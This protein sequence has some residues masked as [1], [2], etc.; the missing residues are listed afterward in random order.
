MAKPLVFVGIDVAQA[1][2]EVAVRPTGEAWQVANDEIAFGDLVERVRQLKPSLIVLEATGGIHLPV[3]A[4]LAA[5]KL[6]VVA[7]NPRQARDFAKAT[8]KLAKDGPYRR[9]GPG[10]FCRGSAS[11][12]TASARCSDAGAGRPGCS[13]P[14]VDGD[15]RG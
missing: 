14:P 8:G 9:S 13:P 7:V 15:A 11:G 10:A 3:V 4:V 5:A 6:P 12:S 2:L 1:T